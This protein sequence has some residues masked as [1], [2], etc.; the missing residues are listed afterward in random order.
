MHVSQ[1]PFEP[2]QTREG[3]ARGE[4]GV[5]EEWDEA[6]TRTVYDAVEF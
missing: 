1:P 5:L 3:R 4:Q 6:L 2:T